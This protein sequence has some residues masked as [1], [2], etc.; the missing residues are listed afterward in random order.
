MSA[1]PSPDDRAV[2]HL[3]A[4]EALVLYDLLARWTAHGSERPTHPVPPECFESSGEVG[5]LV[6]LLGRLESQLVSPFADNYF[7]FVDNARK[8]L[9]EQVGDMKLL[10]CD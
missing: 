2:I 10:S 5:V 7:E 8:T 4:V 3:N 9:E 6:R 1:L